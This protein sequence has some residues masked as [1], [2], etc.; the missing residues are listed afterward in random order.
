VA[1]RLD[2]S[3]GE[4]SKGGTGIHKVEANGALYCRSEKQD[5]EHRLVCRTLQLAGLDFHA[6]SFTVLHFVSVVDDSYVIRK[7][8]PFMVIHHSCLREDDGPLLTGGTPNLG[9]HE[10]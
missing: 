1:R 9:K 7:T 8:L 10:A 2:S 3:C 4:K 6:N 5:M